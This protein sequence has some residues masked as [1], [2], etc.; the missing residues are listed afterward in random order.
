MA[1]FDIAY[2]ITAKWEGGYVNDPDDSGGETYAGISRKN[3]P[4][5]EG[6]PHVD[7]LKG[8]VASSWNLNASRTIDMRPLNDAVLSFYKTNFWDKIKGD[9]INNQSI[10]NMLYDWYVNSGYHAIKSI[11][12]V[13][14][15]YPDGVIGPKTIHL[16][17]SGG[18]EEIFNSLRVARLKFYDNIVKNRPTQRKFLD[19]WRNRTNDIVF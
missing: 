10:A 18:Q 15:A 14:G 8:R 17:N 5:W 9:Q 19:G 2:K 13:V 7:R 3:W 12:E 11:Q 16:I 1:D 6:W 4:K